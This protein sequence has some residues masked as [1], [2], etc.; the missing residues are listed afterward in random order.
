MFLF[1]K[2]ECYSLQNIYAYSALVNLLIINCSANSQTSAEEV[3]F[4]F[5]KLH[6]SKIKVYWFIL[7]ILYDVFVPVNSVLQKQ[8]LSLYLKQKPAIALR[9][10]YENFSACPR[11]DA[12]LHL[13]INPH[14]E[15]SLLFTFP[16]K[17][18]DQTQ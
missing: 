17:A 3:S 1:I 4:H 12:M 15:L 11:L 18:Y 10:Q 7:Q 8:Q 16:Q 5:P 14:G 13:K 9:L 6:F 2:S